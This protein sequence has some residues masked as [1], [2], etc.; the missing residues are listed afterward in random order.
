MQNIYNLNR[1]LRMGV[2]FLH[3]KTRF[4]SKCSINL[5]KMDIQTSFEVGNHTSISQDLGILKL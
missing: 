1:I 5:V 2:D 4:V 3:A